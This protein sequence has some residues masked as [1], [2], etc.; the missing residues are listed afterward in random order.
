MKAN[1]HTHTRRC[2]HAVG[3]DEDYVISAIEA[4]YDILGFSDHTPW[5]YASDFQANMRM[6]LKQFDDYYSS[7]QSLQQKYK[8][9]IKILIG[10]ECE[11]YPQYIDWLKQFII[12]K[13]LDYII[14][15]NHYLDTDEK[16]IY[17][18]RSCNEP[19]MLNVYVDEAIKGMETGLYSY[20]AHPDL[21]MRAYPTF[22][23]ECT[24]ASYRLCEAAKRLNVPLEYNLS[25][26]S[27]NRM[28]RVEEYPHHSFWEIAAKVGNQAI[29]GVDA[30]DNKDLE[31]YEL[32]DKAQVYLDGIGIMVLDRLEMKKFK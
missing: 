6:T 13:K 20:L 10:L 17:F 29:I 26:A 11:Y 32:R 18:G 3:S 24:K 5:K 4:G 12:D 2:M 30:H 22:D 1:Y 23:D 7:I 16:H 25:G 31:N 8:D 21:F 14:F 28:F 9:Q 19:V 15:G 27:Y